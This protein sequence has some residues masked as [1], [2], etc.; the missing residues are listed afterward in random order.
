MG[1]I[2]RLA[3]L[4]KDWK[5][6]SLPRKVGGGGE[7]GP[8]AGTW[9]AAV[10]AVLGGEAELGDGEAKP[11]SELSAGAARDEP[12]DV[13]GVGCEGAKDVEQG[14][15]GSGGEGVAG[16]E[17]AVV[18]EEDEALAGAVVWLFG[19][20]GGWGRRACERGGA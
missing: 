4:L 5:R 18:V 19:G 20:L 17:G 9:R 8:L 15:R 6:C 10:K 3:V 7:R 13:L 1:A 14:L 11:F 12:Y 2:R 16:D